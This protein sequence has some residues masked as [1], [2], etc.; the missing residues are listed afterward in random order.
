AKVIGS[1]IRSQTGAVIGTPR[2]MS[3]EQCSF[4]DVD[5]RTDVYAAGLALYELVTGRG[6]F[7][8]HRGDVDALRFAHMNCAPP[9]PSTFAPVP[10]RIEGVI[11][12]ALAKRP[13]DR[14]S[15]A[16]TMADALRDVRGERRRTRGSAPP[17][18]P[19]GAGLLDDTTVVGP[20]PFAAIEI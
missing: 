14:F 15:S 7:D 6:P 4:D 18:R 10:S 13:E 9:R 12:R 5:P 1:S 3:P 19:S 17:P 8:E 11:L 2:M 20:P 16:A